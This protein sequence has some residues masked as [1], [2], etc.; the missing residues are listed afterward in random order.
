MQ[1]LIGDIAEAL[2]NLDASLIPCPDSTRGLG[3]CVSLLG[4]DTPERKGI[5]VRCYE[6]PPPQVMIQPLVNGFELLAK[7]VMGV[8]LSGQVS[9]IRAGLVRPIHQQ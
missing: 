2:A 8:D 5:V 3:D 1:V 4:L 6:H 7:Y 9:T